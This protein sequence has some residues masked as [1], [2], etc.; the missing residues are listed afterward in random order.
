MKLQVAILHIKN[1]SF[2]FSFYI[3]VFVQFIG[4]KQTVIEPVLKHLIKYI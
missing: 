3:K 2:I 1:N 4:W